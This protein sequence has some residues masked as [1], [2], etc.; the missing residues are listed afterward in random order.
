MAARPNCTLIAALMPIVG[1]ASV[2]RASEDP[3]FFSSSPT[4]VV[5]SRIQPIQSNVKGMRSY[6]WDFTIGEYPSQFGNSDILTQDS[7]PWS[8][9]AARELTTAFEGIARMVLANST[10]TPIATAGPLPQDPRRKMVLPKPENAAAVCR[11]H[12]KKPS[13]VLPAPY[14]EDVEYCVR[15]IGGE[16]G[17]GG[18]EDPRFRELRLQAEVSVTL[19][20][21]TGSAYRKPTAKEIAPF[22]ELLVKLVTEIRVELESSAKGGG[23]QVMEIDNAY[24]IEPVASFTSKNP[25]FSR[26][27]PTQIVYSRT[28]DG[29]CLPHTVCAA[30]E[31]AYMFDVYIHINDAKNT[32]RRNSDL[33]DRAAH[34]LT[35]SFGGIARTVLA[36][37]TDTIASGWQDLEDTVCRAHQGKAS[38]V[39]PAPYFEDVE[40]CVRLIGGE[41]GPF[42]VFRLQTEVN[43]SLA[44]N[45]GSGY[46][47][48]QTKDEI[49]PFTELMQNLATEIR[50]QLEKGA[51]DG[52]WHVTEENG[53]FNIDG[54]S[55]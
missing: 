42:R 41:A 1:L 54:L 51:R 6:V 11:A 24:D 50:V 52:G 31:R 2:A 47:E 16:E 10:D 37:R 14:S 7:K 49:T 43:V 26:P 13:L 20:S 39:L 8:D 23:W 12:Q 38:L 29:K 27:S 3:D 34:D 45:P 22:K 18:I 21:N 53:A 33:E 36:S 19:S 30:P 4:Q 46:H 17:H 35:M 55:K 5:Y 9:L 40:Y 25:D 44:K 32:S 28:W 48:P 15:L